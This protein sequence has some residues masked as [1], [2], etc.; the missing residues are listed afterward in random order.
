MEKIWKSWAPQ[1][2]KFFIWPATNN[3]C[4]TGD[5]LAKT[6][7]PHPPACPLCDQAGESIQHL[8]IS[9]IFARQVWFII[10]QRLDWAP[11]VRFLLA[12]FQV[13][14]TR[15]S[16]MCLR[17]WKK[18]LIHSLPWWPGRFGSTGMSV[19]LMVQVWA[20]QFVTMFGNA[21]SHCIAVPK[22]E[23]KVL[24]NMH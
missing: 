24:Y 13:G 19:S 16:R 20:S 10:L 11:S 3:R 23:D 12:N 6:G 5:R 18:G 15:Q 21:N 4:W 2:C 17:R 14:G 8:L 9:C 22:G 1:H 7:L